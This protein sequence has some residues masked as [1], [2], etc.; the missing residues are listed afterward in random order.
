VKV[1]RGQS[2]QLLHLALI[3]KYKEHTDDVAKHRAT[4]NTILRPG[5][6]TVIEAKDVLKRA[7][8]MKDPTVQAHRFFAVKL[9][10]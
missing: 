1:N 10:H 3:R 9:I 6:Y 2:T 5:D 4:G 8:L 7:L